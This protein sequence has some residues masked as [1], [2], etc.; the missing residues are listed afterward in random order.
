MKLLRTKHC[1]TCGICVTRFDHHCAW[2]SNCVGYNNHRSFF[3]YIC[4]QFAFI[5]F[6]LVEVT[7][8]FISGPRSPKLVIPAA[9]LLL[10]LLMIL[11]LSMLIKMHARFMASDATTYETYRGYRV[12]FARDPQDDNPYLKGRALGKFLKDFWLNITSK[13]YFLDA[14]IRQQSCQSMDRLTKV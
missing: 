9:L 3:V 13:V 8:A 5:F 7:T 14:S 11:F 6:S 12:P 10:C 4:T 1:R 2:A